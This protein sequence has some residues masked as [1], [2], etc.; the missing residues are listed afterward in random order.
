MMSKGSGS[1]PL[2]FSWLCPHVS[3]L[4]ENWLQQLQFQTHV[5][6]LSEVNRYPHHMLQHLAFPTSPWCSSFFASLENLELGWWALG[7]RLQKGHLSEVISNVIQNLF[8]QSLHAGK[9]SSFFFKILFIF[10]ER[11]GEGE[12]KGEKHQCVFAS[13]APL[14]WDLAHNP[15]VPWL[16][17][18][19]V[20]LCFTVWCSIQ[21]AT[22]AR[23][24]KSSSY[25]FSTDSTAT[26]ELYFPF[27][28][29][30]I[31]WLIK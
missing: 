1:I 30:H 21:W 23:A 14:T 17:I 7:A 11:R 20:T 15:G 25:D 27:I 31:L 5:L 19:P 28:L 16:G 2:T 18:K 3:L 12:R 10:R 4:G 8:L 24:D 9:S 13:P 29:S 26:V 6:H 22:P